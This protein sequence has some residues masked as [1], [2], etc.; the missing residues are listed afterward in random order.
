[1]KRYFLNCNWRPA[2]LQ[3]FWQAVSISHL[4]AILMICV[5]YKRNAFVLYASAAAYVGDS[6]FM[7]SVTS[8]H[9]LDLKTAFSLELMQHISDTMENS[10]SQRRLNSCW[11]AVCTTRL[12]QIRNVN[13][14]HYPTIH[15]E[16][17][18]RECFD[19]CQS[20]AVYCELLSS[21]LWEFVVIILTCLDCLPSDCPP[22]LSSHNNVFRPVILGHIYTKMIHCKWNH[23]LPLRFSKKF[24]FQKTINVCTDLQ[25]L[26][27]L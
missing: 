12:A 2:T 15:I 4:L 17:S 11:H 26:K 27:M 9:L 25:K 6:C 10:L 20:E 13:K 21:L 22:S 7:Q 1:M 23:L 16:N 8:A 14:I 19:V 18:K 5:S 24:H 3:A